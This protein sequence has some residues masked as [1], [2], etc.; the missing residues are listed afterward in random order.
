M[1]SGSMS[2]LFP[3]DVVLWLHRGST[4]SSHWC[5]CN[6]TLFSAGKGGGGEGLMQW[7]RAECESI[8]VGIPAVPRAPVTTSCGFWTKT[9]RRYEPLGSALKWLWGVWPVGRG[10]GSRKGLPA[11]MS[12]LLM[13]FLCVKLQ[14]LLWSAAVLRCLCWLDWSLTWCS[15]SCFSALL[16]AAVVVLFPLACAWCFCAGVA[17]GASGFWLFYRF[18]LRK[19]DRLHESTLLAAS[20]PHAHIRL[21]TPP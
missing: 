19:L 15:R 5:N 7:C 18:W 2:L 17:S 10:S 14:P 8:S 9:D 11:F 20:T 6:S 12:E 3:Y 13:S 21:C 4:T 1:G 16:K